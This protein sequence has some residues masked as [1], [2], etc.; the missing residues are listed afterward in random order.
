MV[1]FGREPVRLSGASACTVSV[2][3]PVTVA[4]V[5]VAESVALTVRVVEPTAVGVPVMRQLLMLRPTSSVPEV[6]TQL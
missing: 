3:W 6:I 2:T 5:G 4:L 1:A